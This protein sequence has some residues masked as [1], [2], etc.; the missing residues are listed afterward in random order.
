[1]SNLA[2]LLL[3]CIVSLGG[4]KGVNKWCTHHNKY[5]STYSSGTYSYK[6]L[7][8]AK[9]ECLER[10]DCF[11]ITK[12]GNEY[13]L[14]KDWRLKNSKSEVSYVPCG[15]Y[16]N[17]DTFGLKSVHGKFLSVDKDGDVTWD[18]DW[19]RSYE[20]VTF[21]Q[22]GK[23]SGYL[24]SFHGKYLTA[25]DNHR[26]EWDKTWKRSWER[27]TVFQHEDKVAFKS[28]H[29]RYLSADEDGDASVDKTWRRS[30]EWFTVDPQNCLNNIECD[31]TKEINENDYEPAGVEYDT[32]KGSVRA[33]RPERVGFQYVD[34]RDSTVQQSTTFKVSE[35]VTETASFTHTAGTSVTVGTSFSAGIPEVMEAEFSVSLSA[36]YE[37]SSGTERSETKT[38]EAEYKCVAPP[39][40]IVTCDAFLYKYK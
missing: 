4:C 14:R 26:L 13:T 7:E 24:K 8:T 28:Y 5:L 37:F 6:S 31:C 34:N 27:F 23:D 11:G 32:S 16:F 33:Y 22:D 20:K 40:K 35:E 17:C 3:L 39:G 12:N 2:V 29:N 36:S 15:G 21:E 10:T 38:R 1:M 19:N 25:S 9:R 18:K 30:Y